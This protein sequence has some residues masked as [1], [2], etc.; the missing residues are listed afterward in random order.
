MVY[1]ALEGRISQIDMHLAQLELEFVEGFHKYVV[2]FQC[3]VSCE[4][5]LKG[6]S[7]CPFEIRLTTVLENS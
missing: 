2:Y 4:E 7:L 1:K 5:L 6:Q 3:R